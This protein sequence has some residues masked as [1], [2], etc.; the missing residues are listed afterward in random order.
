MLGFDDVCES[1]VLH[2]LPSVRLLERTSTAVLIY[3]LWSFIRHS[4]V[5]RW[6]CPRRC[7]RRP[8]P[9]FLSFYVFILFAMSGD[10]QNA[11]SLFIDIAEL[12]DDE[13]NVFVELLFCWVTVKM[14]KMIIITEATMINC[15][16]TVNILP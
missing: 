12:D 3:C 15:V 16:I 1:E 10:V 5:L 7:R 13:S 14:M 4:S 8:L 6:I 9:L 2:D 11:L